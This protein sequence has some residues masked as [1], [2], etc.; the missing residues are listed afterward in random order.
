MT[1]PVR[2]QRGGQGVVSKRQEDHPQ[3]LAMVSVRPSHPQQVVEPV[4]ATARHYGVV[5]RA[6]ALGGARD[7]VVVMEE[8]QGQRGQSLVTR[9]GLP[10]VCAAVSW[11][12]VGRILGLARSRLARA[13]QDGHPWRALCALF[14]TWWADAEGV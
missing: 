6:V 7:R 1:E 4:E 11:D 3:R 14:R 12:H 2:S 5:G 8:E 9:W 10:R 13:N